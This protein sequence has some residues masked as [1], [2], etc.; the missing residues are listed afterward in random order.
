MRLQSFD[1]EWH[2]AE[3]SD[4]ITVSARIQLVVKHSSGGIAWAS[5]EKKDRQQV[6]GNGVKEET[7][8]NE[9]NG[10]RGIRL[11]CSRSRSERWGL[12]MKVASL[13]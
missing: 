4:A 11:Q 12:V 2:C 9:R 6:K 13:E 10:T 3:I 7:V 8:R 5:A 1:K